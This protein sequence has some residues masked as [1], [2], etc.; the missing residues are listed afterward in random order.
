MLAA[1]FSMYACLLKV[2]LKLEPA[3]AY[4]SIYCTVRIAIYSHFA[5][6]TYTK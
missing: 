5:H 6:C 2:D 4:Y 3:L 1:I